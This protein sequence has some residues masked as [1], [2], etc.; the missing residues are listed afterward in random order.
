MDSKPTGNGSRGGNL[1]ETE[2]TITRTSYLSTCLSQTPPPTECRAIRPLSHKILSKSLTP[3]QTEVAMELSSVPKILSA[4]KWLNQDQKT[5]LINPC[6]P[7]IPAP[8]LT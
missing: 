5:S 6:Y 2:G 4:A 8:P 7:H 3:E 1:R